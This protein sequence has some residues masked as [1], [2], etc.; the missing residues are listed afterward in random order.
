MH[1]DLNMIQ[2]IV[3]KVKFFNNNAVF[4]ALSA[5][6]G[7]VGIFFFHNSR[8]VRAEFHKHGVRPDLITLRHG[9]N[10]ES[11]EVSPFRNFVLPGTIMP[12]TCPRQ[13]KAMSTALPRLLPSTTLMTSFSRISQ[14]CILSP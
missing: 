5:R 6:R 13:V 11:F 1:F 4:V 7:I 14:K 3:V 2:H 10:N 8:A 12:K 9:M